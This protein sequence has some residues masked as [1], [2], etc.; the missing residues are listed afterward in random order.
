[1]S[2]RNTNS[3]ATITTNSTE[4]GAASSEPAMKSETVIALRNL[5]GKPW[6]RAGVTHE[7]QLAEGH[8]ADII[9]GKSIRLFG[10]ETNRYGGPKAYD[11]TF[12]VGD[13]AEYGSYN[14]HYFGRILAIGA[15]T[16]RIETSSTGGRS[17]LLDPYEF[18]FRNRDDADRKHAANATWMD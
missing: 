12:K 1:M 9:P 6:R 18:S 3:P 16:V 14:L 7:G 8:H 4:G 11:K 2:S 17:R 15:K 10:I 13:E 5:R